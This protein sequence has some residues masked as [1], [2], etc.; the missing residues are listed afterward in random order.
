MARPKQQPARLKARIVAFR[1]NDAEHARL[2]AAAEKANLRPAELAK[3]LALS[4]GKRLV[5]KAIAASGPA[6]IRRLDRVG[7]N[8]NQLVKNAHIFGRVSPQVPELCEEIKA[9][10]IAAAEQEEGE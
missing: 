6:L 1:L 2:A 5:V 8:L 10:I 7:N 9:I 4:G 3:R